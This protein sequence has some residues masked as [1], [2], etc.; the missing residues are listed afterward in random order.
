M[1]FEANELCIFEGIYRYM[2]AVNAYNQRPLSTR[3]NFI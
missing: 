1:R 3:L 2:S